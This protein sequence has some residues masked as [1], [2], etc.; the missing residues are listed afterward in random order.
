MNA[1]V[2][3]AP[4]EYSDYDSL[5][6][7]IQPIDMPFDST[8]EKHFYFGEAFFKSFTGI[9]EIGGNSENG[10]NPRRLGFAKSSKARS[11]V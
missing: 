3:M 4:S 8:K 1:L 5:Q 7:A 10:S 11:G 6:S 2:I 9:F